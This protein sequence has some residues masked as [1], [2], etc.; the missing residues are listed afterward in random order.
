MAYIFPFFKF[1]TN[2]PFGIPVLIFFL[3]NVSLFG[4]SINILDGLFK[5]NVGLWTVRLLTV[6]IYILILGVNYKK[7]NHKK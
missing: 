7:E 4:K 5:N 1:R 6:L 3:I 2:T